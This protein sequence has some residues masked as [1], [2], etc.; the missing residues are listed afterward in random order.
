ME[1]PNRNRNM[2]NYYNV[3]WGEVTRAETKRPGQGWIEFF[4]LLCFC[5]CFSFLCGSFKKSLLDLLQYCFCFM[6]WCFGPKACG[7]LGPQPG[8]KPIPLALEGKVLTAG[9]LG[10]SLD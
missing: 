3:V 9:P 7:I 10:K 1:I 6:F 8:I 2:D 4:V 5:F